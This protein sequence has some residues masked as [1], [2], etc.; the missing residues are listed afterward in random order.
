MEN[1]FFL[2]PKHWGG[3]IWG[4]PPPVPGEEKGKNTKA[5]LKRR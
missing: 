1:T 3:R 4:R 2:S 5:L